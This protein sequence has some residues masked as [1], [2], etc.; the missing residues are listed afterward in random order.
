MSGAH[1]RPRFFGRKLDFEEDDM[2]KL[3]QVQQL[4]ESDRRDRWRSA[5]LRTW[6]VGDVVVGVTKGL[7]L[8]LLTMRDS[9]TVPDPAVLV[10]AIGDAQAFALQA[11]HTTAH[12]A[13]LA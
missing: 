8:S 3:D 11:A 2:R 4:G 12:R 6:P 10:D 1:S 5:M 13:L 7:D 9:T